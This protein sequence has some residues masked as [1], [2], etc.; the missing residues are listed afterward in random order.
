MSKTNHSK[1]NDMPLPRNDQPPLYLKPRSAASRQE[2]AR[3]LRTHT[4]PSRDGKMHRAHG[5]VRPL[6]ALPV[7]DPPLECGQSGG[8]AQRQAARRTEET[9]G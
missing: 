6:C 1:H 3:V 7:C 4:A 2:A 8:V 5:T 9:E